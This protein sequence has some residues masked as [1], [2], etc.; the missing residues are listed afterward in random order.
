MSFTTFAITIRPLNGVTD[1]QIDSF[2]KFVKKHCTYYYIIT[3][4]TND[5]RHIHS[6]LF[7]KIPKTRSNVCTYLVRLFKD[8][9]APEKAVL[10]QGVKILYSNDF[11][12][13]Y[14]NK[15]DDTIVIERNLPEV[16]SL[17]AFYP[18]KPLTVS[19][20]R[21]L[22]LHDFMNKLESLWRIHM[23]PHTEIETSNA[24][25]FLFNMMYNER[26]I[27]LMDDKKIIQTARHLVRWMNKSTFCPSNFLPSFETEEGPG[28]HDTRHAPNY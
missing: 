28:I 25:D 16:S 15:G 11:I 6:A 12:E 14:M 18:P 9:S 1:Q 27:G 4:K 23:A 24:R 3:E 19:V 21:Q 13:K 26:V 2:S 17:E 8:L 7:F 20:T 22:H 10:Q 5:E